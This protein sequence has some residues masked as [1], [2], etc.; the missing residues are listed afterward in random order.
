MF[1]RSRRPA[2][3]GIEVLLVTGRRFDFAL[4]IA[5]QFG[6]PLTMIVN[7]GALVKS[8]EG[9]T[10]LRRLLPRQTAIDVLRRTS[11][12][13]HGAAVVFD[14]P[15]ANQIIYEDIDWE[16]PQR[17]DYFQRNREF[18]ARI[19]PLEHALT[20]DPIQ[21]MYSGPVDEMRRAEASLRATQADVD[22]SLAVT[23]YAS[24][25]F[26]LVDVIALDC[27]KGAA[28]GDWTARLGLVPE[29]VMAIGDNL[30]D[31]E[32]L[33]FAGLPIIMANSVPELKNLGWR[34]TLSNDQC[35]VAAAIEAYALE[36]SVGGRS[37]KH[38]Q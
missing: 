8:S 33:E 12:F 22:F 17:R 37:H 14:R 5:R 9:E 21:V 27:S 24:R 30:N 1:A 23:Y 11:A 19:S 20:E 31:R 13:G 29:E 38:E 28:L 3:A 18:I 4:P 26:G 25:D 36:Q 16:D 35:G 32:M 10:Y 6:C 2:E 34:E 15:Q 7:N